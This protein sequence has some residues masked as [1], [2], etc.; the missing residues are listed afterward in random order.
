MNVKS[1]PDNFSLF[2]SLSLLIQGRVV[3]KTMAL[4]IILLKGTLCEIFYKSHSLV[5]NQ[6]KFEA[7]TGL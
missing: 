5:V 1:S 4:S 3:G 2:Y 7:I 6:R